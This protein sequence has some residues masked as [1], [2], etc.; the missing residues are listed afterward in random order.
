MEKSNSNSMICF[1]SECFILYN[2]RHLLKI[3]KLVVNK[4]HIYSH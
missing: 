4:R 3:Q 1:G 2:L